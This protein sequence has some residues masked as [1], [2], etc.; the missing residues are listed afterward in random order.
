MILEP[1]SG[2]SE[3]VRDGI[4]RSKFKTGL[5]S[6]APA[7][8]RK[9]D[10]EEGDAQPKAKKAK[11]AKGVNP[12]SVKKPKKRETPVEKKG[13]VQEISP[14]EVRSGKERDESKQEMTEE[15]VGVP[16]KTRR[17]RRHKPKTHLEGETKPDV[18]LPVET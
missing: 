9:R 3:G 14:K 17:K 10:D 6:T 16:S 4:E 7:T 2:S 11:K 12:L 5:M 13:S 18:S 1:M 15:G 8:K